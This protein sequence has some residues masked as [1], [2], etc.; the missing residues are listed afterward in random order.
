MKKV[1]T[2]TF[3]FNR[4]L[5]FFL[6]A[7]QIFTII[8]IIFF[9]YKLLVDVNYIRGSSIKAI[10]IIIIGIFITFPRRKPR[11]GLQLNQFIFY[12]GVGITLLGISELFFLL[13]KFP[14]A[15]LLACGFSILFFGLAGN[16]CLNY[17]WKG[18]KSNS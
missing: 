6:F 2:K 16:I 18:Q 11:F 4:R 9:I 8:G 17:L 10:F 5:A 7:C 12:W 14:I 15:T 1:E 13:F 3:R